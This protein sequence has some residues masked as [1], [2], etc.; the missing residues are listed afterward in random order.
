MGCN[1]ILNYSYNFILDELITKTATSFI[2]P[3]LPSFIPPAMK[4]L[5]TK[6]C[7]SKCRSAQHASELIAT[8]TQ[9]G[10][11][12]TLLSAVNQCYNCH[13]IHDNLGRYLL[14]MAAACG[15]SELVEWLVKFKKSDMQL[16]TLENGWT[17]AHCA[18]FYGHIDTLLTLIKLGANLIKN[19]YDRLT[20]MEHLCVDKWQSVKDSPFSTSEACDVY[21]WGSNENFNL[22][23]GHDMKKPIAEAVEFFKKSD[24]SISQVVM[25]KFHTVFLASSGQVFTCGFGISGRLGHGD[26]LTLM[27]PKLV[28]AIREFKC[29]QVA[30]S[31][32]NS[33]FLM[34]DGS[35]YGCGGNLY[36]QLGQ[37]GPEGTLTPKMINL[38]KRFKA[39]KIKHIE[40]S[41]F[42]VSRN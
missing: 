16:K 29:V 23:I 40:C 11:T 3:Q 21:S 35:L 19:D 27:K 5:D 1:F 26:E 42:H 20:P 32:D 15:R 25:S 9:T 28:E 37:M 36:Q 34:F 2:R 6:S 18:A 30:A 22:G 10:D 31:R 7:T 13:K 8:I 38:G 41:K 14:H 4:Y 39:R 12:H 24:T 17:P 33:Y